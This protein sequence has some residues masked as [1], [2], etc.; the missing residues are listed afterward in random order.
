[1]KREKLGVFD[2]AT[3]THDELKDIYSELFEFVAASEKPP[4]CMLCLR[5]PNK[6]RTIGQSH[7][8]P[9]SW[10]KHLALDGKVTSRDTW[11]EMKSDKAT[12]PLLCTR[13]D[14][15]NPPA[16]LN[17]C[18]QLLAD[19]GEN[20]FAN[21]ILCRSKGSTAQPALIER[22][23]TALASTEPGPPIDFSYPPDLFY[24]VKSVA[25]R[26]LISNPAVRSEL[27]WYKRSSMEIMWDILLSLR[28]ELLK[29]SINT[30]DLDLFILKDALVVFS[31]MKLSWHQRSSTR[32]PDFGVWTQKDPYIIA[33]ALDYNYFIAAPD[34][35]TDS[36]VG[37]FHVGIGG[38]HFRLMP[39]SPQR[40]KFDLD[41]AG[42]TIANVEDRL[43][44]YDALP[45]IMQQQIAS[46]MEEY[47][48][49]LLVLT[50]REFP[51]SNFLD[52]PI[53]LIR[54][55]NSFRFLLD[56]TSLHVPRGYC[57][58]SCFHMDPFLGHPTTTPACVWIYWNS[59]RGV[60]VLIICDGPN[61]FNRYVLTSIS[62][63]TSTSENS[64]E[65]FDASCP[66]REICTRVDATTSELVTKW[67]PKLEGRPYYERV[68]LDSG[69]R[70]LV[71]DPKAQSTWIK[72]IR[73]PI[74]KFE[75]LHICAACGKYRP[76]LSKSS[77][78]V[79]CQSVYCNP[80]CQM[81]DSKEH[82]A[83][84]PP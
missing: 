31:D 17:P 1:M 80:K 40:L 36:T 33:G 23:R 21:A 25:F 71:D 69:E 39:H 44:G 6:W 54:L 5:P 22:L 42:G 52:L 72:R 75:S 51:A 46:Q 65:T 76:Y 77:R 55:P 10:L 67:N 35:S 4:V 14:A 81:R 78:C 47:T 62:I 63:S 66:F 19:C 24:C 16:D 12:C 26:A 27:P 50:P 68:T 49:V 8:I 57:L 70:V 83:V 2:P 61:S 29:P 34:S 3:L 56:G 53:S 43:L 37:L 41:F 79:R 64:S 30:F 82:K 74:A 48:S 15:K 18:E 7:I 58:V 60:Y 73:K 59:Q 28:Q 84:C 20:Y 11:V 45:L 32:P 13:N 38:L 9:N